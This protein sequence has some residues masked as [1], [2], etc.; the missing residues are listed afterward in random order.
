MANILFS[1]LSPSNTS[2][3]TSPNPTA[4]P[5]P[6]IFGGQNVI[7]NNNITRQQ[8]TNTS[9]IWTPQDNGSA[10]MLNTFNGDIDAKLVN[11]YNDG[12]NIISNGEWS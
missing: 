8:H 3:S 1:T 12:N 6:P 2:A 7:M 5:N 4:S 10:G 9:N 11:N